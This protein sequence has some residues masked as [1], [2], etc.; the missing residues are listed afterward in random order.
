MSA[1]GMHWSTKAPWLQ[2]L[3]RGWAV[4]RFRRVL[5]L[6]EERNKDGSDGRLLSLSTKSG[7]IPKTWD[8]ES[9]VRS[10]NE[11]RKYWLVRPGHI[12]VNPM[13]VMNGAVAASEIAGVISPDYRVYSATEYVWPRFIHYLLHSLEYMSLYALLTRG[14]TTFD[15]RISKVD[16]HEL[17]TIVPP[18]PTQKAIAAFLDRKTAAIDA[19]IEKKQ[20]LLDLLAEKRAALINQAVTKGLDPNVAMKDS[21]VPWIGEIPAQWEVKML[22]FACVLQRG[23]DLPSQDRADGEVPIYGGGGVTGHHDQAMVMP[24]GVVTGRY[25]TVGEVHLVDVPFW[26]L[27]TSLYVKEFWDNSAKYIRYLLSVV[28]MKTYSAKS[29]V[30]GIDRNDVHVIPVAMPILSEQQAIVVQLNQ[31]LGTLGQVCCGIEA[32]IERLQEYRQALITAAV[33]GQLDIPEEAA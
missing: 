14:S 15:R 19:L 32:Q 31:R 13:W 23:F 17:P 28:P 33:T 29:A 2:S 16:F 7:V 3:P 4:E 5:T 12:I 8:D 18:L 9:Q 11:L 26:P 6:W 25:G 21:G 1:T 10:G 27:N 20:K 22:K 30:P 24:P